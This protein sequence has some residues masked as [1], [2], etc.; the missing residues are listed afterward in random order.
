M[1]S[2][3]FAVMALAMTA[4]AH[5]LHTTFAEVT[6]DAPHHSARVM[7]RL[8]A[9]DARTAALRA[10]RRGTDDGIV[11]YVRARFGLIDGA[12]R[13]LPLRAC[14]A[15]PRRTGDLLWI[16]LE[17]TLPADAQRVQARDALLCD[18]FDDQINIVQ[19]TAAVGDRRSV[20]FTR[21]DRLK[22]LL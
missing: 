10:T 9:D 1:V 22:P 8:F 3:V 2:H 5:P 18:L 21:S 7:V 20:L 15:P 13:E 19:T 14:A 11:D 17:A 6:I 16:C 12:G 4:N